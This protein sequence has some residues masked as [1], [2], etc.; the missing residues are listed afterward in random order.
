MTDI[1]L[2]QVDV[3]DR[4]REGE[5]FRV[6]GKLDNKE[7]VAPL[8]G[9]N[10]R[11][12]GRQGEKCVV[13]LEVQDQNRNKVTTARRELCA[14]YGF[15]ARDADFSFDVNIGNPGDYRIILKAET[16]R[17]KGSGNKDEVGPRIVA[18]LESDSGGGG[19]PPEGPPTEVLSRF[20]KAP[21]AVTSRSST[22]FRAQAV[23]KNN[24]HSK[25]QVQLGMF[26]NGTKVATGPATVDPLTTNTVEIKTNIPK[27]RAVSLLQDNKEN[28]VSL[29]VDGSEK[30]A[31]NFL[32]SFPNEDENGGG[33]GGDDNKEGKSGGSVLSWANDNPLKAGGIMALGTWGAKRYTDSKKGMN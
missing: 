16:I 22:T 28:A 6:S 5:S 3:P 2:Q 14:G 19:G 7:N 21:K 4:V 33:G 23:M 27:E 15:D 24:T 10:C 1:E 26:I 11:N 9:G 18:V 17:K 29:S 25:Q 8:L 12:G 13:Q 31:G 32:V 20:L 30:K